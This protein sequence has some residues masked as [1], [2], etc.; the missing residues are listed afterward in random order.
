MKKVAKIFL[1]LLVVSIVFSV[2]CACTP[3]SK[4]NGTKKQTE[5]RKDYGVTALADLKDYTTVTASASAY[6]TNTTLVADEITD[7]QDK[8]DSLN[9]E[10]YEDS[11]TTI[12]KI[13]K[14]SD[15]TEIVKA[16]GESGLSQEKMKELVAYIAGKKTDG[17]HYS[18]AEAKATTDATGLIEDYS[19]ISAWDDELDALSGDTSSEAYKSLYKKRYQ[20]SWSMNETLYNTGMDGGDFAR[21]LI[22]TMNYAQKV[23]KS[24][25]MAA[26][27]NMTD[28]FK[29]VLFT[30]VY[31][32]REAIDE[33]TGMYEYAEGEPY[34]YD[35]SAYETLISIRAYNGVRWSKDQ[36][37]AI[38]DLTSDS[39]AKLIKSWGYSYDYE[40]AAHKALTKEEYNQ[41]I[42]YTLK[43]YLEDN[44][45]IEAAKIQRKLYQNGYRYTSSFYEKYY[46]ALKTYAQ[47]QELHEARVYGFVNETSTQTGSDNNYLT[48]EG[49]G[50]SVADTNFS[51]EAEIKVDLGKI[52]DKYVETFGQGV[53]SGMASFLLSSDME[54]Y[55]STIDANVKAQ[56]TATR[57]MK[58]NNST[59]SGDYGTVYYNAQYDLEI[60]NL[61]SANFIMSQFLLESTGN[62][63]L[64]KLLMY[65]IYNTQSDY[66]RSAKR[67]KASIYVKLQELTKEGVYTV[68]TDGKTFTLDK[69]SALYNEEDIYNIGRDTATLDSLYS[70]YGELGVSSQIEQAGNANFKDSNN[71]QG[72]NSNVKTVLDSKATY[73]K[74][75]GK[76][77]VDALTDALIKKVYVGASGTKYSKYEAENTT[78]QTI[79][80]D[81]KG[82][83]L[84]YDTD[85][86]L[87]RLLVNHEKVMYYTA[88]KVQISYK[89][90]N[91]SNAT[92]AYTAKESDIVSY[93][94]AIGSS[95]LPKATDVA[96]ITIDGTEY[97]TTGKW[98]LKYE[99]NEV[100]KQFSFYYP[101]DETST[102]KYDSTLYLGLEAV[103]K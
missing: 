26:D 52:T 33:A 87:S 17:T 94:Q 31:E 21:A 20:K 32:T 43:D 91:A 57:T 48:V 65:Q 19:A 9:N 77:R 78:D 75:S 81:I 36:T 80:D 10:Y 2:L 100:T 15:A 83:S 6:A 23:I 84:E 64:Q 40:M 14:S 73:E 102:F 93:N 12:Q 46:D 66:I 25:K 3:A 18:L 68:S 98:Y 99:Y 49:C 92:T 1:V 60:E 35:R 8:I 69:S 37:D 41:N 27:T 7:L 29:D 72:V 50:T 55:Y 62:G 96:N 58:K 90:I 22:Y 28:Y 42:E 89:T 4:D 86:A 45:A 76:K 47:K 39:K 67:L 71:T 101:V 44:E 95:F 51:T 24:D 82:K 5:K 70:S 59:E 11:L 103:A 13:F 38:Y 30:R 85:W 56:A 54:Y 16:L 79:I 53:K 97:K 61:K 34:S 63:E 88:G 74:E